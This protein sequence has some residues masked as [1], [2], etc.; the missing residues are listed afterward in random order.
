MLLLN[1]GQRLAAACMLFAGP[2]LFA[3]LGCKDIVSLTM[4]AK[5]DIIS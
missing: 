3:P 5:T 4:G 2:C 1:I